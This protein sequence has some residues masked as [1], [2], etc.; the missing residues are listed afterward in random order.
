MSRKLALVT[1]LLLPA[2]TWQAAAAE[3]LPPAS[4]WI[5]Q[6]ALVVLEVVEADIEIQVVEVVFVFGHEVAQGL[7]IIESS[8]EARELLHR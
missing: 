5:P 8:E 2:L 1:T 3:A 7:G 6:D 4:Q